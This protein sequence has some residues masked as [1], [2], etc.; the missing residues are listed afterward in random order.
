MHFHLPS[1]L[2]GLLFAIVLF[3]LLVQWIFRESVKDD[4]RVFRKQKLVDDY[5]VKDNSLR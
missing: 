4:E 3:V 2:L 1:F 5:D